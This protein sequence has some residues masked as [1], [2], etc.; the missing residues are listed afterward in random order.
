MRRKGRRGSRGTENP[1]DLVDEFRVAHDDARGK[2]AQSGG[3]PE[4]AGGGNRGDDQDDHARREHLA[5]AE[6]RDP[7]EETGNH[8]ARDQDESEHA[9]D[10]D[11]DPDEDAGERRGAGARRKRGDEEHERDHGEVL[12]QRNP[13]ETARERGTHL[14]PGGEDRKHDRRGAE[15]DQKSVE[16]TASG[17]GA[18]KEAD[19]DHEQHGKGDLQRPRH[20]RRAPHVA[21]LVERDVQADEEEDERDAELRDLLDLMGLVDPAESVRSD[22]DAC[23]QI[24]DDLGDPETF[25]EE[26]ERERRRKDDR[27]VEEQAVALHGTNSRG[28]G[29]HLPHRFRSNPAICRSRAERGRLR[30]ERSLLPRRS[31]SAQAHRAARPRPPA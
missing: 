13:E 22:E 5:A 28:S 6:R 31:S 25:S 15:S 8:H 27:D 26:E 2:R 24:G 12:E 1:A 18:K 7:A 20:E 17:V 21:E 16:G 19:H 11:R 3:D 23:R 10:R 30:P 14:V 4:A 29:L 9:R